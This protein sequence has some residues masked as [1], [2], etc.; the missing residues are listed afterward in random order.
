MDLAGLLAGTFTCQS[1]GHAA[2]RL[3]QLVHKGHTDNPT[4]WVGVTKTVHFFLEGSW[5]P[6]DITW[7]S[8]GGADFSEVLG[9]AETD[10][11][12]APDCVV[13]INSVF[14]NSLFRFQFITSKGLVYTTNDSSEWILIRV[15]G[16]SAASMWRGSHF[17]KAELSPCLTTWSRNRMWEWGYS[18]LYSKPQR[19]WRWVAIVT[20]RPFYPCG[21]KSCCSLYRTLGG[22][23]SRSERRGET[24]CCHCRVH[25][26]DSG[27]VPSSHGAKSSILH[28]SGLVCICSMYLLSQAAPRLR[29]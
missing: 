9:A 17:V 7:N 28:H 21:N 3:A 18:S 19:R 24:I 6:E 16:T 8:T 27:Q 10:L 25:N 13:D 4:E 15:F 22:S 1:A 2:R 26:C 5:W 20:C 14:K 23:Q 29:G 11:G 12:D